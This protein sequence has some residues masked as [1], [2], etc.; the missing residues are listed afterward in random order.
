MQRC[1]KAHAA[2][3]GSKQ[4]SKTHAGK[5]EE[6]RGAAPRAGGRAAGRRDWKTAMWA[7][8]QKV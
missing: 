4:K 8:S 2:D 3:D 6:R 1:Q 5:P 7:P